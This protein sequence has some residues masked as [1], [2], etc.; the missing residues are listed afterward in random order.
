MK[1]LLSLVLVSALVASCNNAQEGAAPTAA[2]PVSSVPSTTLGGRLTGKFNVA[3]LTKMPKVNLKSDL[4]VA[5]STSDGTVINQ[6]SAL[7]PNTVYHLAVEGADE[8]QIRACL[9]FDLLTQSGGNNRL[10][11]ANS[12]TV[13]THSDVSEPLIVSI[14]PLRRV[15]VSMYREQAQMLA[16]TK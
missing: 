15:G 5:L 4:K 16:L 11:N 14:I 2:P 10:K 13:K 3:S 12:F 6:T 1:T 7:K 8:L 9:G